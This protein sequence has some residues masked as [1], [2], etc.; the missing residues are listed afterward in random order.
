MPRTGSAS[1]WI[2]IQDICLIKLRHRKK[3]YKANSFSFF[4]VRAEGLLDNLLKRE[5]FFLFFTVSVGFELFVTMHGERSRHWKDKTV[6]TFLLHGGKRE[7]W[8]RIGNCPQ[9]TQINRKVVEKE[10]TML[11]S[12][13]WEKDLRDLLGQV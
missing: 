6:S 13:I 9:K 12:T 1:S 11:C 3:N 7:E 4:Y 10:L 5:T 2:L 8:Y